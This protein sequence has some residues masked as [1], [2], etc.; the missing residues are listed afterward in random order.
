M[1]SFQ[2]FILSLSLVV[3]SSKFEMENLRLR[4]YATIKVVTEKLCIEWHLICNPPKRY[5]DF[6]KG[7]TF[8]GCT[9]LI[10]AIGSM[11]VELINRGF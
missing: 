9:L 1:L 2:G 8:G 3:V 10:P 11:V 5:G 6:K 4:R 7:R